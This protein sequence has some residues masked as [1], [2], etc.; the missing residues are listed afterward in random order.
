MARV[1]TASC[2]KRGWRIGTA[3]VC[4]HRFHWKRA[5]KTSTLTRRS[6]SAALEGA[7]GIGALIAR[8][9]TFGTPSTV[10]GL[11][12]A[13][14][15]SYGPCVGTPPGGLVEDYLSAVAEQNWT[16]LQSL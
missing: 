15:P 13:A 2:R 7:C 12:T 1:S 11:S 10:R 3:S 16:A 6:S 4:C 8:G 14:T 9:G 5:S